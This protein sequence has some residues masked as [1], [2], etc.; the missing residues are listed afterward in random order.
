[1][2]GSVK[3]GV[4]P[5]QEQR[6]WVKVHTDKHGNIS[7]ALL[8]WPASL[9]RSEAKMTKMTSSQVLLQSRTRTRGALADKT[10]R[11]TRL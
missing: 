7:L 10:G 8:S 2:R 3:P 9:P 6:V 11:E 4:V 5:R 1:M